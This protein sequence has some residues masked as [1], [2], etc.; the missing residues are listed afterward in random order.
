[1]IVSV[2][3]LAS[4]CADDDGRAPWIRESTDAKNFP[5]IGS[6]APIG[7]SS[8]S[9]AAGTPNVSPDAGAGGQQAG[10]TGGQPTGTLNLPC[11]G[12]LNDPCGPKEYCALQPG[13]FCGMQGELATCKPRPTT[14]DTQFNPVCGCNNVVYANACEANAAGVGV[15]SFGECNPVDGFGN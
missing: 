5:N 1:V 13:Q 15:L 4:G 7:Q 9:G 2:L 14:C 10:G 3:V 8:H 12:F 11:S 6:G